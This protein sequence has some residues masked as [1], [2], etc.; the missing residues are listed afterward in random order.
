[1]KLRRLFHNA[2]KTVQGPAVDPADSRITTFAEGLNYTIDM[3]E[4]SDGSVLAARAELLRQHDVQSDSRMT[5]ATAL[6]MSNQHCW[7]AYP[8]G[9]FNGF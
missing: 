5:M 4:L 1:M 9:S 8:A 7:I 3:A 6:R 2:G